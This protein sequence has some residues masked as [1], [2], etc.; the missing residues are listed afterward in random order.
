MVD[1]LNFNEIKIQLPT[2]LGGD[3]TILHYTLVHIYTYIVDFNKLLSLS[4]LFNI[5][6]LENVNEISFF[7]NHQNFKQE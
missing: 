1:I 2:L 7:I 6:D 5:S 3:F 4:V